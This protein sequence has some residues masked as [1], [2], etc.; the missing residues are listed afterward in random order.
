MT[1]TV[2]YSDHDRPPLRVH[3]SCNAQLLASATPTLRRRCLS[4]APQ[5]DH[6]RLGI[7]T[8][9]FLRWFQLVS[10]D[11]PNFDPRAHH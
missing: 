10:G 11:N 5:P 1:M 7:R 8:P 2:V 4:P 3:H 6:Q 9:A